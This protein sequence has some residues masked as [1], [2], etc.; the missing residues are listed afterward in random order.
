MKKFIYTFLTLSILIL[1]SNVSYS[2]EINGIGIYIKKANNNCPYPIVKNVINNSPASKTSI[3]P[4]DI[5]LK[6]NGE[7]TSQMSILNILTALKGKRGSCVNLLVQRNCEN[8]LYSIT[9]GC[10]KI[11]FCDR[12][13]MCYE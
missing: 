2:Q 7:D 13:I 3:Q 10:I 8:I 12:N 11:P 6:I 4:G 9:K 5:I 1:T